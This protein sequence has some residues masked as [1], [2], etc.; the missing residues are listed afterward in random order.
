[1]IRREGE[2]Y[3]GESGQE[4]ERG[5]VDRVMWGREGECG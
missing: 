1:M 4:E 3:V 2:C 5:S